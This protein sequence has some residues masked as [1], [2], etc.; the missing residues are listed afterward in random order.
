[1]LANGVWKGV[2]MSQYTGKLTWYR[3]GGV[4]GGVKRDEDGK[5]FRFNLKTDEDR[6]AIDEIEIGDAV[7]FDLEDSSVLQMIV[8]AEN[9]RKA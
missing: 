9:V 7:T 8:Y 2:E 6:A 3:K 4:Q 1:M 5:D